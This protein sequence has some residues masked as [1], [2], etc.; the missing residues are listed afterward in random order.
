[1][2]NLNISISITDENNE[3]LKSKVQKL[4]VSLD[5][6]VSRLIDKDINSIV[7]LDNGFHYNKA[8]SK[9]FNSFNDEVKLTRIEEALFSLLLENRG[10]I[11]SIETIHN[12]AWK[13][14]NMTRFTLR[15]KVKTLRD[16]TY[17]DLIKN[18][19]N[20]GYSMN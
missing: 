1:M 15:N 6:Y 11:V 17:Y 2:E 10:E 19:S 12:V 7:Q 8:N 20:I 3:K 9:L 14:K 5:E 13:G 16:K 4:D 18:H